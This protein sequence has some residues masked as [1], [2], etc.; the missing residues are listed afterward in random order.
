MVPS[1]TPDEETYLNFVNNEGEA[2]VYRANT[3]TRTWVTQS[4]F[5]TSSEIFVDDVTKLTNVIVQ[6]ETVPAVGI[7]GKYEIGLL[8]DKR[9]ITNVTVFNETTQQVISSDNY[10]VTVENLS[11]LLKITPG[12]YISENDLLTITTLEGNLIYVNG[13]QIKFG[14][15]DFDNNS[16]GNLE[17]GVN[18]TAK[19]IVINQYTELYGL[20]SKNRLADVY[21]NQTWNS[22]NFNVIMGDPLQISNT[23]AAEFLNSDII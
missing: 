4:I 15:V 3:G 22:N 23:V 11:P 20:L 9:L 12:A 5:E 1:A 2:S 18:G 21:Y 7:D 13:E 19:Q 17:R 8:A 6:N 16:L 14:T 10:Q